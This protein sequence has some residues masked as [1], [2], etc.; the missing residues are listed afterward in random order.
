[1]KRILLVVSIAL[2]GVFQMSGQTVGGHEYVD[3]GL[4]VKWATCNVGASSPAE[5]GDF[6]AWGERSPKKEYLWENYEFR[7][8]GESEFDVV[9]SRYI[10][11]SQWGKVD[12]NRRLERVDDAARVLWGNF[13]R[14]PTRG[15]FKEL[16]ENCTWTWTTLEG[17]K[18]YKVTSRINGKSIFLPATGYQNDNYGS[19]SMWNRGTEGNYWSSMINTKYSNMAAYLLFSESG[20]SVSNNGSRCGG[21]AIR[22]VTQ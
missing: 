13:W 15:E 19:D 12:N 21:R 14:M 9:F 4:S 22:P 7:I 17:K 3:L 5:Y 11:D 1:M 16:I 6:F 18:G 20:V 2:C 10:T 8:S